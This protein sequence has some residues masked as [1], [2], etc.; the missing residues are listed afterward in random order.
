MFNVV[1]WFIV[2][3][4]LVAAVGYAAWHIYGTLKGHN[5]PCAGCDGC[6]LKD[7]KQRNP[8]MCDKK[9]VKKFGHTE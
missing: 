9:P 4:V 5:D 6:A 8:A 3:A 2:F 7:L 1:Q